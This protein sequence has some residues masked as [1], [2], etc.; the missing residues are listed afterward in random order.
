MQVTGE[1]G[2]VLGFATQFQ[3]DPLQ[4]VGGRGAVA[5]LLQHRRLQ[6]RVAQVLGAGVETGLA[7]LAGLQQVVEYV[8]GVVEVGLVHFAL[9]GPE[10]SGISRVCRRR[11]LPARNVGSNQCPRKV[12]GSPSRS[13]QKAGW[14]VA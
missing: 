2:A 9:L 10:L 13:V 6:L 11:R 12:G 7:I 5:A 1:T 3:D 8:E 4:L 14:M